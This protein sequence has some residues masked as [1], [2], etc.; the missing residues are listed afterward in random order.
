MNFANR[1]SWR[2]AAVG[3]ASGYSSAVRRGARSG[4]ALHRPRRS[5]HKNAS[6]SA[7]GSGTARSAGVAFAHRASGASPVSECAAWR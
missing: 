6:R 7:A 2:L 4:C 5:D 3:A 1:L